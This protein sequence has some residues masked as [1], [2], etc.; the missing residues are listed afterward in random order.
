MRMGTKE[1]VI[2]RGE[3]YNNLG[4]RVRR[5]TEP[6]LTPEERELLLAFLRELNADVDGGQLTV[7]GGVNREP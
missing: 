4:R 6:Q 2:K 5:G 3:S 7:D 1:C